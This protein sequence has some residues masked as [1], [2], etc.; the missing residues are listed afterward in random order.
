[1]AEIPLFPMQMVLFPGGKTVLEIFETRYLDMV[2]DCLRDEVGFGLVLIKEGEQVLY[3]VD[4]QLPSVAHCGT[5]CTIVD[6]DQHTS[7]NLEITIEGQVKFSV[8]DQYESA[9]RLMLAQVE[10]L[11]LED[12]SAIPKNKQHLVS[13][14]E[15]L[16]RHDAVKALG[17]EVDFEDARDVSA[18]LAEL[19]PCSNEFKQKML[20][21]KSADL[22]LSELERLILKM[23]NSP[24]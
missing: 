11:P 21:I 1:M 3:D 19:L 24:P 18:R 5:Y 7:G 4:Q 23:Q 12:E 15:S 14:L 20:E 2:R 8:R 10:F 22:R 17:M 9:D 6:F 16:T 13:L